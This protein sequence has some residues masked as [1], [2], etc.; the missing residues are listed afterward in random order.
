MRRPH[1]GYLEDPRLAAVVVV[2]VA[3]PEVEGFAERPS[4]WPRPGR[5]PVAQ[6]GFGRCV[7]VDVVVG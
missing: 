5:K 4:W 7:V 6:R 2:V 3:D 1:Q